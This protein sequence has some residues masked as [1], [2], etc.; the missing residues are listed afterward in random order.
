MWPWRPWRIDTAAAAALPI[1]SGTA[2][3]ETAFG[4]FGDQ[5]LL[6][7]L[8]RDEAA[9]PGGDHAA[10]PVG[11]VGQLAVLAE[12]LLDR[13]VAGDDRHLGEA[14]GAPRLLFREEVGRLEIEAAA[15][16]VGDPRLARRPAVD[17]GVAPIP[18]GVTAPTP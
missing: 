12:R 10:D 5:L 14:V 15:E 9:D 7:A 1:I 6:L 8:E 13:L 4:P 17:Q 18:S 3:G 16:A 11:V 2:S